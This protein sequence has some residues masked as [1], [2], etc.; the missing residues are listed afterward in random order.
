M[1]F[2]FQMP[3]LGYKVWSLEFR[4]TGIRTFFRDSGVEFEGCER[5]VG[6]VRGGGLKI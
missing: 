3:C 6:K 1:R 2:K 5:F 4:N